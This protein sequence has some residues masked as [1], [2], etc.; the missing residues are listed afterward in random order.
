MFR[1]VITDYLVPPAQI[2]QDALDGVA[3]VECLEA[4]S[5]AEL[6]ERFETADGLIVFHE[7]SMSAAS[8]ERLKRCRVLVRCGVGFDNVDLAVAGRKGIYVCNVPD[9]GVD[10]VADHAIGLM[11]ACTRKLAYVDRKLRDAMEPWGYLAVKPVFRLA[12]STLGIIGLGRIGT[13]TALR[14]K[15]LRMN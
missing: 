5:E 13:A 12:G 9:Y 7:I 1:V 14:A 2:E 11:I 3:V 10:E 6:D 4:R 8:L 15:A